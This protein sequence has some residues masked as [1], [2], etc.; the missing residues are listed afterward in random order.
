MY[1]AYVRY[2]KWSASRLGTPNIPNGGATIAIDNST[3]TFTWTSN[4][5]ARAWIYEINYSPN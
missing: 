3:F 2:E 1:I 4:V 5:W